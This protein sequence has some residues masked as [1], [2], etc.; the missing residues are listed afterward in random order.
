MKSKTSIIL[1]VALLLLSASAWAEDSTHQQIRKEAQKAYTN[2][3]WKD[4]F[5]LYRKLSLETDNDPGM[6]GQDFTRP[7]SVCAS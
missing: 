6:I 1:I 4:A 7:G 3:N 5:E 2:G